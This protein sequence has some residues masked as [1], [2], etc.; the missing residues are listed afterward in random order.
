VLINNGIFTEIFSKIQKFFLT[1]T[2]FKLSGKDLPVEFEKD[3]SRW[4][5]EPIKA[6]I[7][8]KKVFRLNKKGYPVLLKIHQDF[9]L[10][11]AHL[12]PYLI[13]EVRNKKIECSQI[14]TFLGV[15]MILVTFLGCNILPP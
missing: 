15:K 13:I 2:Y 12:D 6:V 11:L 7:I 9:I 4:T 3:F 1:I 8:P 14:C 5:G 10:S